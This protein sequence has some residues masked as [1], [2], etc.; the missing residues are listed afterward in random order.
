MKMRVWTQAKCGVMTQKTT[1]N[2]KNLYVYMAPFKTGCFTWGNQ[3]LDDTI[4]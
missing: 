1:K 4:K 3:D 2:I